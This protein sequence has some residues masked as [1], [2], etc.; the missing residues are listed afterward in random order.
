MIK[1]EEGNIYGYLTVLSREENSQDRKARWLCQCKCGKKVIVLGKNLRNGNSRS[2]GCLQKERTIQSNLNRANNLIGKRF[3]KLVVVKENG[4]FDK[5]N[6]RRV[7]QYLCECDCGNTTVVQ[8]QYL[9]FGDTSSCGCLLSKGECEIENLLKD[10]N[11]YYE[12]QYSFPNLIDKTYLR[13]DFAIFNKNQRLV[14]LI[15]F[16][17]KQHYDEN[18]K[19]YSLDL[20]K[21]DKMKKDYCNLNK[22]PLII[23]DF[24]RNYILQLEDLKIGELLNDSI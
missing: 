20:I 21:H 13:F 6:G 5:P 23:I 17:G 7:R 1:N 2:C 4:F 18:S 8:H 10:N 9:E 14:C 15:E 11:I 3:G 19:Y 12:K 24:K 16:Q 22:I